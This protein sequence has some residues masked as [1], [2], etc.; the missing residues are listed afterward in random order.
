MLTY[1]D[2]CCLQRS[3]AIETCHSNIIDISLVQGFTFFILC[4]S[5]GDV[6]TVFPWI[7]LKNI[8]GEAVSDSRM[9]AEMPKILRVTLRRE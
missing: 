5:R 9:A 2:V 6:E 8:Q 3:S 1:A 4:R 7:Y